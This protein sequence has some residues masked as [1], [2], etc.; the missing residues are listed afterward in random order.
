MKWTPGGSDEDIED[1]RGSSPARGGGGGGTALKLGGGG[2]VVAIL[3]A[4]VSQVL[5]VDLTG[6]SSTTT[7]SQPQSSQS[8]KRSNSSNQSGR[9]PDPATDP[10]RDL[11]E[12]SKFAFNDAQKTFEA[13]FAK[14]NVPYRHAKLVIFTDAVDT[15][16]GESSSAV[17]PFYC[18]PDEKVYID[19]SFYRELKNQL[20][21][22]GD[23]AQAYVIAHEMGHHL[24]TLLGIDDKARRMVAKDKRRENDVSVRQELQADCFAGVWG[25]TTDQR[26][27]LESGDVEEAMNA[28]KSIGDDRLQKMSGRRVNPETF[29]HGTSEQRM[30]WFKRGFDSGSFDQCDT[31]GVAQP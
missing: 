8:S 14:E 1:I 2:A 21:A 26:K 13:M 30:R 11:K 31:F 6:G 17:G 10:D 22:D 19:L 27:M 16:C 23:F 20:G 3:L 24:Q 25:H 29:T 9:P 18:P 4:I 5:G 28:A 7:S 12:F 15:G